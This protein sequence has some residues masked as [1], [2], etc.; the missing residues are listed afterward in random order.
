MTNKTDKTMTK[1]F[2]IT[3][4][5][6]AV[7]ILF[8]LTSC[9]KELDSSNFPINPVNDITIIG[10]V[11]DVDTIRESQPY[12]FKPTFT[13][14]L[15]TVFTLKPILEFSQ[16]ETSSTYTYEWFVLTYESNPPGA[17]TAAPGAGTFIVSDERILS[18]PLEGRLSNTGSRYNLLF[19]ITDNNT[20]LISQRRFWLNVR[21][22]LQLGYWI[23]HQREND[24]DINVLAEWDNVLLPANNLLDMRAS[25]LPR[26][27]ETAKA[28]YLFENVQ[29]PHPSESDGSRYSVVIQ[30]DKATNSV[31]SRDFSWESAF[32]IS[33]FAQATNTVLPQGFNP[34]ALYPAFP[35]A[36]GGRLYMYYDGDWFLL[37]V[38]MVSIRF[39]QPINRIRNSAVQLFTE[40]PFKTAPFIF[41]QLQRGALLFDNDNR[42]FVRHVG[43]Q[44]LSSGSHSSVFMYTIPLTDGTTEADELFSWHNDIESLLYM[45]NF[46]STSGFGI[47]KDSRLSR[48][49]Y[50]Q[51]DTPQANAFSK[52]AGKVFNNNAFIE[53]VKFFARHPDLPFLYVVTQ[54]NKVWRTSVADGT[55]INAFVDV[56]NELRLPAG[57]N[58]SVF[59]FITDGRGNYRGD[60][61][62]GSYD[63]S[64]TPGANGRV[65]FFDV[66]S[67]SGA[68]TV[69][70]YNHIEGVGDNAQMI[71][72]GMGRPVDV[73]RKDR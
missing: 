9:A 57:H 24:F 62:V 72:T 32:N 25:E 64:G 33:A 15:G 20:G 23:L 38:G 3:V 26:E 44:N 29:A 14:E 65:A 4:I 71:F 17:I 70:T 6:M 60:L 67:G 19:R 37:A 53:S 10:F 52:T 18:L 61:T 7:A 69:R 66:N 43:N 40:P 1:K 46:T 55:D 41:A 31:R 42:R 73:G 63:P 22:R 34:E 35:S 54:D 50:I 30:T 5:G 48:Y 16:G 68:F 56:T 28:L 27:G 39:G 12:D 13:G 58:I 49:R 21:D 47:L 8:G 45:S 2:N 36:T 51:F 59:R 11:A